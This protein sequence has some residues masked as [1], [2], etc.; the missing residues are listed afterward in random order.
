VSLKTHGEI[1]KILELKRQIILCGPPGTGKTWLAKQFVQ[2]HLKIPP[3]KWN[4]VQFHPAYNY[5]DFVRGVQVKTVKGQVQYDT[6]H[7]V[8]SE[9]CKAARDDPDPK[10]NR[11]VLII[12]EINRANLAAVL[13]ELIYGLEYRGKPV[14][15]PYKLDGDYNLVVPDNL[16]IIGTMNTADRS[17][18]HIDYAVRRRFAFF[19]MLPNRDVIA[20]VVAA[21]AD[22]RRSALQLFDEVAALFQGTGAL[23]KDFFAD[24]VQPGHTYFLVENIDQLLDNF[25]YQ[26]LP[27]LHEYVK[28]GVLQAGAML[29]GVRLANPITPIIA[30][31]HIRQYLLRPQ[32]PPQQPQG[33]EPLNAQVPPHPDD[34]EDP[35]APAVEA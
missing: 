34:G 16:Y 32:V 13:G 31:E 21:P 10:N 4:I 25:V 8:F 35:G 5:E 15:T 3:D 18:G 24:D 14:R 11:Y 22:V 27:L 19:P 30:R 26:V 29:F 7:R 20:Q 28:D 1:K 23:A 6:V 17:I 33:R 2:H 9:M 12:D